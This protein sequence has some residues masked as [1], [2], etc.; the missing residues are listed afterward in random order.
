MVQ[1]M[2]Q[3]QL[4]VRQTAVKLLLGMVVLG[5]LIS[6]TYFGFSVGISQL[7]NLFSH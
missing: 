5:L 3:G 1:R 7:L 6:V 2:G 4:N